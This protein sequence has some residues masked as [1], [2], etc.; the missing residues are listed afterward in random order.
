M[1]LADVRGKS[2]KYNRNLKL[3]VMFDGNAVTLLYG[4]AAFCF[5]VGIDAFNQDD[6]EGRQ[7][8][9]LRMHWREVTSIFSFPKSMD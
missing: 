9:L 5:G 8:K 3:T 2:S 1:V 7:V 4:F 6:V